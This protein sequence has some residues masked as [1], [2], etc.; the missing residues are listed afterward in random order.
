LAEL[1]GRIVEGSTSGL[2]V[3]VILALDVDLA[4]PVAPPPAE[5]FA[6]PLGGAGTEGLAPSPPR[7][8]T[9]LRTLIGALGLRGRLVTNCGHVEM[10]PADG[11][12]LWIKEASMS[13]INP[14]SLFLSAARRGVLLHAVVEVLQCIAAFEL[15]IAESEVAQYRL[16]EQFNHALEAA[17]TR[18]PRSSGADPRLIALLP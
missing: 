7:P 2:G 16:F 3:D 18:G 10:M 6:E 8:P 13:F 4:P 5:M 9:L 1:I 17:T 12:H 14:H 15:P 11:E